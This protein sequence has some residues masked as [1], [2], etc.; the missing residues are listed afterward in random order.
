MTDA[1]ETAIALLAEEDWQVSLHHDG[2]FHRL[3]AGAAAAGEAD[4]AVAAAPEDADPV[5][6][7]NRLAVSDHR[8]Q[9][10][11]HVGHRRLPPAAMAERPAPAHAGVEDRVRTNKAMG[12]R[13]LP[14]KSWTRNRG[15]V[16]AANLAADLDAWTRLLGL[17][18][19]DD[20]ADA[21]PDT[22]RYRS[23][24]Y[25]HGQPATPATDG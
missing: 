8:H 1:E 15:W 25:Q 24:T 20:L 22:L 2:T 11:A 17:H 5:R 6:T 4:P 19:I 13:N 18:D 10:P 7:R 3:A 16:L 12:L 21:E 9:H 14:S 23:G